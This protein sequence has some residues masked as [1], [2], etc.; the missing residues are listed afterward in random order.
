MNIAADPVLEFLDDHDIAVPKGVLDNELSVS[1]SSIARALDD[2][3]AR[4]LIER[5][6]NFSSY[7]R[8]TDLGR[9]YLEGK[10]DA[11]DLDP[12]DSS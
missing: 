11:D 8:I 3:E 2:L 10:V 5:D 6:D 9:D 12:N 1:S 7:Y 4:E